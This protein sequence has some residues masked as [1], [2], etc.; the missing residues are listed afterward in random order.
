MLRVGTSKPSLNW[1]AAQSK[2]H[3][4]HLAAA[5]V[6]QL[7]I[8]VFL[9][10]IKQEQLVG[11]VSRQVT[12]PL[13]LGYFFARFCPPVS[14]DAIRY[15]RGVVRVVGSNS[16]MPIPLSDEIIEEIRARVQPDGF[17]LLAPKA[18]REG[19]KVVIEHGP[20]EGLMGRVEQESSDGRRVA[21]LL[22]AISH[23][24]VSIE[25]RWLAPVDA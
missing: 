7:D 20:F 25:K 2:P 8:E 17:V 6:A 5:G 10:K 22:E 15:A 12:K 14:L 9:P 13:F 16:Q 11:G 4:E 3:Q 21:L 18:F 19:D 24:R 1:Y 23:A